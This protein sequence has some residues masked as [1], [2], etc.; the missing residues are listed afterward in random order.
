M[1]RSGGCTESAPNRRRSPLNQRLTLVTSGVPLRQGDAI[2]TSLPTSFENLGWLSTGSLVPNT[3]MVLHRANLLIE[4]V[5]LAADRD[6]SASR[7]RV[8]CAPMQSANYIGK[9]RVN[10]FPMAAQLGLG[11]HSTVLKAIQWST[12]L[13]LVA[14]VELVGNRSPD[15]ILVGVGGFFLKAE[16]CR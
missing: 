3:L 1:L 15:W 11:G 12:A 5:K 2:P 10:L 6:C 16:Q 4:L 13:P 8:K 9:P 14:D 7:D